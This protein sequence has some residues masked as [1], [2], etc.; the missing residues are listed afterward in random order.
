MN[1]KIAP[2]VLGAVALGLTLSGCAQNYTPS[3]QSVN[4]VE[5]STTSGK[6]VTCAVAGSGGIDC[7]WSA[8]R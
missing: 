1:K 8:Q 2:A 5:V 3:G 7:D 4:V 6:T